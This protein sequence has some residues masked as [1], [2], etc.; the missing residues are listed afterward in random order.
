MIGFMFVSL[1]RSRWLTRWP[2]LTAL[3]LCEPCFAEPVDLA[4]SASEGCPGQAEFTSA[5]LA[6]G[7]DFQKPTTS[8]S[9]QMRLSLSGSVL[10]T[11][12]SPA[13]VEQAAKGLGALPRQ[14][15][16]R[17]ARRGLGPVRWHRPRTAPSR[18]Q[19]HAALWQRA[20]SPAGRLAL[21]SGV[22]ALTP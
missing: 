9:A 7:G 22:A 12:L 17:L 3:T 2:L 5:V 10:N 8:A 11:L 6:R 19:R 13:S 1:S 21:V 14:L 4:Y 15:C 20:R 16:S 18:G